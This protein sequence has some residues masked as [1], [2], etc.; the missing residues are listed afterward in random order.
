MVKVS[1][2]EFQ[3]SRHQDRFTEPVSVT[4]NGRER[5]VRLSHAYCHAKRRDRQ[6]LGVT[7]FTQDSIDDPAR[8]RAC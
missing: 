2:A 1:S 3:N 7:D 6:A 8:R 5:I 4:R